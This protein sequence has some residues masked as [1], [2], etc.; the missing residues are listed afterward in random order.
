VLLAGLEP[1][2][3]LGMER[4]LAEAGTDVVD[5]GGSDADWLVQ[6]AAERVPQ[7][8]VLGDGPNVAPDLS[9]RL[10]AAAPKATL[11]LWRADARVVGVLEPGAETPRVIPAPGAEQLSKELVGRAAKGESCPST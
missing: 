7:A 5:D 2:F 8:I 10:R 6:Q 11:V 3:Q 9:S 4:A 1:I